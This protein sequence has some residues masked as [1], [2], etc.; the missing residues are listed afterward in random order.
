[1]INRGDLAEA[2]CI[3]GSGID[4]LREERQHQEMEGVLR[5]RPPKGDLKGVGPAPYSSQICCSNPWRC[6][7][8]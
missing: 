1:M 7:F 4:N 5:P 8:P 6:G 3:L 2:T